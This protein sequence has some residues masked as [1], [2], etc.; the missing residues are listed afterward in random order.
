[1]KEY[2]EQNNSEYNIECGKALA[3]ENVLA[4]LGFD[5]EEVRRKYW[6]K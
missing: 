6:I 5:L 3:F 4:M 1:M 2:H